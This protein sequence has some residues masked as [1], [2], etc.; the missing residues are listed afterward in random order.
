MFGTK[1][2]QSKILFFP[3]VLF[4]SLDMSRAVAQWSAIECQNRN[5]ICFATDSKLEHFRSPH[6]SKMMNAIRVH[7]PTFCRFLHDDR[8]Q[9]LK[10]HCCRQPE[11][12]NRRD[13]IATSAR[14]TAAVGSHLFLILKILIVVISSMLQN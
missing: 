1:V 11:G 4:F 5:R 7:L 3:I 14:N 9:H 10:H 6:D 12:A 2:K 8:R 13:D